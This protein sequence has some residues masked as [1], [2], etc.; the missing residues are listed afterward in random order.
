MLLV[1]SLLYAT[2][3]SL[4]SQEPEFWRTELVSDEQIKQLAGTVPADLD[5]PT[6]VL[7]DRSLVVLSKNGKSYEVTQQAV[8]ILKD[9][10]LDE[11]WERAWIS[12]NSYYSKVPFYEARTILPDGEVVQV[13]ESDVQRSA[14]K[15][16]R[17][18]LRLDFP[19][20]SVGAILYHAYVIEHEREIM[21]G[22]FAGSWGY[23]GGTPVLESVLVVEHPA[24]APLRVRHVNCTPTEATEAIEHGSRIR[25]SWRLSRLEEQED[26]NYMPP[27][28]E[29]YPFTEYST[30]QA[31]S[32]IGKWYWDLTSPMLTLG[33]A[34]K[35]TI[36]SAV[37]DATGVRAKAERIWDWVTEH[38]RY[39]ATALGDGTHKPAP[40]DE[41]FTR[42]YGDCKDQSTFLVAALQEHGIPSRLALVAS[43]EDRP[44]EGRLPDIHWFD[45]V[46]VLASIEG[47]DTWLDPAAGKS[48]FGLVPESVRGVQALVLGANGG[49]VVVA[50]K[51]NSFEPECPARLLSLDIQDDGS[52]NVR[53]RFQAPPGILRQIEDPKVQDGRKN[54]DQMLKHLLGSVF[55]T[56]KSVEVEVSD[57]GKLGAMSEVV[58]KGK[59]SKVG[60]RVGD[61]LLIDALS[62]EAEDTELDMEEYVGKNGKRDYPFA[63][64]ADDPEERDSEVRV[65]PGWEV[66][67]CLKPLDISGPG[68]RFVRTVVTDGEWIRIKD[69]TEYVK[70]RLPA[71]DL[72]KVLEATKAWRKATEGR[73]LLRMPKGG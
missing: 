32:D 33:D 43:Y 17:A 70:A 64:E 63:F 49:S 69:R 62:T 20:V 57:P 1:V 6:V 61:M 58:V 52:A 54:F 29:L 9:T 26:E 27:N 53:V 28:D 42:R 3:G 71:S 56:V 24:D 14:V 31:W 22:H 34:A 25:R 68:I 13:K 19:R 39:V 50:P 37:G 41:T 44:F 21:P 36:A 4:V 2:V 16:G 35:E 72:D 8:K 59:A 30:T 45:H 47:E 18:S 48:L 73:I 38:L 23:W 55:P 66:V 40:P 65:P 67:E 10:G 5:A 11:G 12:Y 46:V 60:T 15:E 51:R 7:L